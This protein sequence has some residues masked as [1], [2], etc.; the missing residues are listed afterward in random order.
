[1]KRL[2]DFKLFIS[3]VTVPMNCVACVGLLLERDEEEALEIE[4]ETEMEVA[5][6]VW[7][8]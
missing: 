2:E 5:D 8:S 7:E 1:M 4:E 6:G 3:K